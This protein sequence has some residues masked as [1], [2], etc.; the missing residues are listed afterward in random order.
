SIGAGARAGMVAPDD[1][2]FD[3]LAGRTY[4]PRGKQWEAA[5]DDWR[6]L[7]ADPAAR[8]DKEVSIDAA[9]LT[10]YVSWGTNP[11]QVVPIGGVVPEP[12]QFDEPSARES[13]ARALAYMGLVAGTPVR[14]IAIDTVFIGSCTNGR[15]EDLRAAAA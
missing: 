10:P 9:A 6:S 12:D 4:S 13:A 11:A 1:V 15:I 14:D 5:L 2:T 7:V 3:Y 8:F